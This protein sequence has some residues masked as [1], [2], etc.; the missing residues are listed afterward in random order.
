MKK[1]VYLPCLFLISSI[2]LGCSGGGSKGGNTP[3]SSSSK[4]I[5]DF[6]IVSPFTAVGSINEQQQLIA[7]TVPYGSEV[8]K[9]VVKFVTTGV[10]TT[11]NGTEQQSSVTVNDFTNPLMYSVTAENGTV[12]DY[13]VKVTVAKNTEKNI[14]KFEIPGQ[15]SSVFADNAITVTIPYGTDVKS[16]IPAIVHTGAA[17]SPAS[18]TAQNFTNPVIYTVTA[19][20]GSTKEYTVTVNVSKSDAK[21]IT[22]FTILGI[23]ADITGNAISLTV[24]Y[25]SDLKTLVPT[26]TFT[27]KSISPLSGFATDFT[28]PVKYTVT[29]DDGSSA[30][31]LVTV[32]LAK[33]DG[34]ITDFRI[35]GQ[36][37]NVVGDSS[38]SVYVKQGSSVTSLSPVISFNG[39]S[40]QPES[41]TA[42]DFTNPVTYT[43][44]AK[45]NAK[46]IY[47]VR[48][49]KCSIAVTTNGSGIGLSTDYTLNI[50]DL[51]SAFRE[52][53]AT[54][55]SVGAGIT[56][57]TGEDDSGKAVIPNPFSIAETLTTYELWNAV[58]L[59]A[60]QNGYMFANYGVCGSSGPGSWQQ[61][62]TS[63]N[64]RDAI[65]WCNALTEFVNVLSGKTVMDCV[66]Y[67]DASYTSPLRIAT[68]SDTVS[69]TVAGSQDCPYLKAA[70]SGNISMS[71]CTAK[72]FRLPTSAEYEYA[73]RYRGSDS[74]NTVY[75]YSNPYYT[76]GNSASGA[77]TTNDDVNDLN[78]NGI[79]DGKEACDEVA[80]YYYYLPSWN[81]IKGSIQT[82][83]TSTAPV[84]SK[85]ANTLGLYD[86]SG[87]AWEFC[88]D[89]SPGWSI[90]SKV[91]RGGSASSGEGYSNLI[92]IGN[93]NGPIDA[94]PYFAFAGEVGF[95]FVRTK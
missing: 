2:I 36:L 88:F 15:N 10:K 65:V 35:S 13:T 70:S 43:V 19:A 5:T 57:P 59:W 91:V 21:S 52:I 4:E 29:A 66:Y 6:E 85:K 60:V 17:V 84:K 42:C 18:G 77:T 74:T 23:S 62:A 38:I 69:G 93:V 92:V 14:T 7:V 45:N 51:S 79:Y 64:W 61:P 39:L 53:Q 94:A 72:G 50:G 31:Y 87:N 47:S 16:L 76:K 26:V 71:L 95:R 63:M 75:G 48:V 56:F 34:V 8:T 83:V 82:G 80:V 44:T 54:A 89:D 73:A 90:P 12:S 25:G 78:N 81:W 33:K 58:R 27:G 3:A 9:L 32:T 20:D 24:P 22:G 41:G 40:V 86:M 30:E 49:Y 1:T 28:S 68:G 11:V 46:V 67:T 37:F 55:D